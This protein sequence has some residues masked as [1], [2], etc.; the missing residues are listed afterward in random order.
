LQTVF[1][2]LSGLVSFNEFGQRSSFTLDILSLKE[3]GIENVGYWNSRG[4]LNITQTWLDTY[5]EYAITQKPWIV[6]TILVEPFTMSRINSD[7]LK[8][9]AQYEGYAIDLIDELSLMLNFKYEIRLSNTG[10]KLQAD[11]TWNGMIGMIM[12]DEAD[13][14]IADLTITRSREQVV[15]FTLPFMNTGVGILFT[16][17]TKAEAELFAFLSPFTA[18]VWT[19][20]LGATCLISVVL[21]LV[22]R[23]SPY[24]WDNPFPCREDEPIL[25][26][27][28]SCKN[29]FWCIVGALM[30]QGS[31]VAPKAFSS[32]L[33]TGVWYFFTLIMVSSYT[34][35]LAAFL[36]IENPSYPFTNAEE[37]AAQTKIGYGCGAGGSTRTSFR[38]ST[39]PTLKKLSEFMESNPSMF[40]TNNQEGKERVLRGGYA[41]FMEGATIEYAVERECNLTQI[42]GLLDSKSY[43]IATKLGSPIRQALS[44]GIL[45]LQEKGILHELYERWWKQKREG[46]RCQES[47][48]ATATPM[49]LSNVGGVFLVLLAV[50]FF[51]IFMCL[52]EL[53]WNARKFTPDWVSVCCMWSADRCVTD[54]V[55]SLPAGRT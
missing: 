49:A 32:R 39:N 55:C 50:S 33:I 28:L 30:Q 15:D 51:A 10:G 47:T 21:F 36:T 8:G 20:L 16:K 44:K 34:A 45:K 42:G 41:F 17:A 40:V 4:G 38:E 37:L 1:R 3:S 7:A 48:S 53:Y 27:D 12:R 5:S 24:E 35:N 14:A 9:N 54:F 2:G 52:F 25:E 23:L 11:G 43:G 29:S 18:L 6:T 26:N 19:C 46:G 13:I 22:G 31:D